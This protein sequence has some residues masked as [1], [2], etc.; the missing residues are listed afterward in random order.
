M[1]T[2]CTVEHSDF[3]IGV[4]QICCRARLQCRPGLL[5]K[6]CML[7]CATL[8]NFRT[9]GEVVDLISAHS[10]VHLTMLLCSSE[11][12]IKIGKSLAKLLKKQQENSAKLTNQRV[13]YAFTSS[14]L[15]CHAR[16]ILPASKFQHS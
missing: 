10:A 2:S 11:S 3:A 6:I 8:H 13:S 14:P 4:K 16:H 1:L 12:I 7:N 15:S 5:C 9:L